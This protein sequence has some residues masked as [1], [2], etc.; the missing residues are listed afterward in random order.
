MGLFDRKPK[1]APHRYAA[2]QIAVPVVSESV[3]QLSAKLDGWQAKVLKYSEIIPEMMTG[4]LFVHNTMDMVTFEI[5]R[6]DRFENEWVTDETP[7]IQGVNR[8]VNHAFKAGRAA[9]LMSLVEECYLLVQRS[10]SGFNF[11]TL[12]PTEIKSK[13]DTVEKR[14]L[15]DG[16]QAKWV[17]IGNDTTIIRIYTPDPSDRDRASGPHKPLLGLLETMALE[18][19]R[20]Q[21]DAISVLAGNG[22]LYVPTEVLPDEVDTLDASDT[23]GSRKGFENALED[24]MIAT[25]ADRQR[26]EAIVPITLYGPAEFADSI[27]HI[28]PTRAETAGESQQKMDSYIERYAR[29]IDLPAQVILGIGDSNHWSDWKVDENT[30]AY[31]LRPRAERIADALYAGLVKQVLINLDRDPEQYRLVP[32]AARAIAK[33]DLSV[34]AIAAYKLGAL[35]PETLIET[36]GFDASD[37]RADAEITLLE[38]LTKK[39]DPIS[40]TPNDGSTPT[41]QTPPTGPASPAAS[42]RATAN[43]NPSLVLRAASRIANQQQRK[44]ETIYRRYL[45]K[46]AND[47]ARDGRKAQA[48]KAKVA[49][50]APKV[51]TAE[52]PFLGYNPGVYFTKYADEMRTATNDE[53]FTF[54]RRIASLMGLDYQLV[55]SVWANEFTQRAEHVAKQAEQISHSIGQRSFDT[56]KPTRIND[57]VVRALTSTA[58]GGVNQPNG[59]AGNTHHPTHA[60]EDP[61]MKDALTETVGSYATQYTWKTGHPDRPYPPHQ[62]LDG[63]SWFSWQEFDKL[64]VPDADSWLPGSVFFPG[65][66]DG[67]QCE[68]DIDFVPQSEAT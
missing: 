66:H 34:N 16:E 12:S 32:D 41:G 8:R 47:A 37:M 7:E 38:V 1:R 39:V 15:V 21:A 27:R 65:D 63:V 18:L 4:Y 50:G 13:A 29:S 24:A 25:I 3:K 62:A 5:Q 17:P 68:Y 67:C 35:K 22:I 55:R 10:G 64:D 52:V 43:A 48:Y 19:S 31:H 49:A 42:R 36:I 60:G 9:A 14:V 57:N 6:F 28:L 58:N 30:W 53:L 45:A 44:L 61:V 20:D 51:A 11:E 40:E 46:I 26:G 59:A 23:P 33:A 54:L 2:H 56:G